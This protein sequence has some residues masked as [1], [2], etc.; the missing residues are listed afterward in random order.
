VC[1]Q[2]PAGRKNDD[3]EGNIGGGEKGAARRGTCYG[4]GHWD[5]DTGKLRVSG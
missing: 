5:G 1:Q 3:W 4:V 2:H